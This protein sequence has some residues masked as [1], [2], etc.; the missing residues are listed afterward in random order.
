[1]IAFL[2]GRL[3]ASDGHQVVVDVGGVGYRLLAPIGTIDRLPAPGG[4]VTLH[5]VLQLR[6]DAVH[7]YGFATVEERVVFDLL[8]G[9]TGVGPKLAL[10][11][12][13]ALGPDG[14]AGAVRRGDA[15]TLARVPGIGRKTAE[16]LIMELKDK[17]GTPAA[18]AG[19]ALM[20]GA[21][22]APGDAFA[23]AAAALEGLGYSALEAGRAVE[24]ARR[25][26]GD[27]AT[28]E[29]ILRQGLRELAGR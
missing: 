19:G 13:S 5:T 14:L 28:V 12:L 20:G 6:E 1:M 27:G 2:R 4:E 21:P 3:A 26:A 11:A 10:A 18:T 7:L 29:E 24:Q 8:V 9:V 25:Q 23:E 15:A 17:L 16:R 22:V